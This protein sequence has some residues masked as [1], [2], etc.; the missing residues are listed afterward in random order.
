MKKSARED[1]KPTLPNISEVHFSSLQMHSH[2]YCTFAYIIQEVEKQIFSDNRKPRKFL[3]F[4]KSMRIR[5]EGIRKS[6]LWEIRIVFESIRRCM[7]NHCLAFC[8]R[9]NNLRIH[10]AKPSDRFYN[11][12]TASDCKFFK[13]FIFFTPQNKLLPPFPSKMNKK[14]ERR[15]TGEIRSRWGRVWSRIFILVTWSKQNKT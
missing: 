15:E 14:K 5:L 3:F 12:S 6:F 13:S 10:A 4:F 2:C 1:F 7:M 11:I 8:R 9:A